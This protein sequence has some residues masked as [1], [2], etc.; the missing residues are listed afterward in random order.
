MEFSL[1]DEQRILRESIVKF[2]Q[3]ELNHDVI[4]RDRAQLFS[5]AAWKKCAE[6]GIQGLP[7]PE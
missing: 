1:T 2:A 7:V 4:E 5:P 3:R 6:I